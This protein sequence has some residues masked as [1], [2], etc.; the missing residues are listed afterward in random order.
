[1]IRGVRK[2][3]EKGQQDLSD[4]TARFDSNSLSLSEECRDRENEIREHQQQSVQGVSDSSSEKRNEFSKKR[5]VGKY[6]VYMKAKFLKLVVH[7][8]PNQ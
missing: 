1:M 2:G 7:F 5:K 4:N 3:K 6:T 8:Y